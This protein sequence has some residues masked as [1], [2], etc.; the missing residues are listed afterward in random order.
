MKSG[1]CRL[2]TRPRE[3][4]KDGGIDTL[5]VIG[6]VEVEP[7][8][9]VDYELDARLGLP[10]GPDVRFEA[11]SAERRLD[12]GRWREEQCIGA[13]TRVRGRGDDDGSPVARRECSVGR[14][15]QAVQ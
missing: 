10:R 3:L 7:E 2:R 14:V 13:A 1:G 11:P 4:D 12:H 6:R 5:E 15:E 8:A 9:G